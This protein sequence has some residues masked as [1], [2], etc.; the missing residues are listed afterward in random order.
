[1]ENTTGKVLNILAEADKDVILITRRKLQHIIL[2]IQDGQNL[3][4]LIM[5]IVQDII[6]YLTNLLKNDIINI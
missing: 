5:I 6:K 3:N 4:K 2:Q 1:M